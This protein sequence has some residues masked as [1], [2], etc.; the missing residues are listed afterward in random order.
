M[1]T[2]SET[3]RTR[4]EMLVKRHNNRLADLNEA[5]GL[6][7]TD[8]TL[9]QIRNQSPSSKTGKP[10]SMGDD[11]ARKIEAALKLPTGWM[12]TPP[13][14]AELDGGHSY[15]AQVALC[16]EGMSTEEQ[17]TVFRLVHAVTKPQEKT[18]TTSG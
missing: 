10:R 1:Q 4:L 12:D 5:I 2:I 8:A 13:T 7:R 18:G 16:M 6:D 14:Y 15:A 3:R 11:I 9:S 17:A